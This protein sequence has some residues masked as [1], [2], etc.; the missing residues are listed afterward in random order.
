HCLGKPSRVY[1]G[2]LPEAAGRA[3][4]PTRA[5]A[6]PG[7]LRGHGRGRI[8][9]LIALEHVDH[10]LAAVAGLA[11]A[12][13]TWTAVASPERAVDVVLLGPDGPIPITPLLQATARAVRLAA[14]W[15]D[16]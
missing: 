8:G 14:H 3:L 6:I 4:G 7:L 5:A 10:A 13:P 1:A 9:V 11:R 2:L 16:T 12:Y 15:T